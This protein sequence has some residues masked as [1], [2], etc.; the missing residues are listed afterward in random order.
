MMKSLH[1]QFI[2]SLNFT[3]S[4]L[5]V[6]RKIGEYKG[7]QD[8]VSK[9]AKEVCAVLKQHAIIESIESSNRLEQITAPRHRIEGLVNKSTAPKDRS[10]REISGYRDALSLIH[11]S[12]QNIKPSVNVIKQLHTTVY[13]YLSEDGGQ[14]KLADNKIVEKDSR[15]NITR[16]RFIPTSA[17]KTPEAMDDLCHNYQSFLHHFNI[18][19]LILVPLLILDF[20]CIHPFTDGNGR[21]ARLLTLLLLYRHGHGV[22]QYISLERIIEESKEGY[23][24]TLQASS[25]GWHA[26]QHDPFPWL[27][28]F[29]G[30]LIRAYK[31]LDK[32]VAIVEEATSA[33]GYKTAQI[34]LAVGNKIKPFSISDIEKDC[35]EISRPMIRYVLRQLRDEGKIYSQGLGRNARWKVNL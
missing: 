17:I 13:R 16:E 10:E 8:S 15:G 12:Y 25:Q 22:G 32:Q 24:K 11:E 27:E 34:R 20:L 21:V 3:S 2:N 26:A 23:Y 30:I 33:K 19:A 35:P 14:F 9:R 28:Y 6:T 4:Q 29:W 1:I 31:E 18:D 7:K 5:A